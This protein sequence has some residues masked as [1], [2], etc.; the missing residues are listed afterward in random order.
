MTALLLPAAWRWQT[1]SPPWSSESSC[2]R[3]TS[4]CSSRLWP[5]WF[6]GWASPRS[7]RPCSAGK[8]LPKVGAGD[9]RGRPAVGSAAVHLVSSHFKCSFLKSRSTVNLQC[10]VGPRCK[11]KYFSYTCMRAKLLQLCLTLC[12]PMDCSLPGSSV[13]GIFQAQILEQVAIISLSRWSSQPRD[14]TW[15]SCLG[16]QILYGCITWEA[17]IGC[18]KILS[19][20]LWLYVQ[21]VLVGYLFYIQMRWLDSITSSTEMNLSKLQEIVED[22]GAW[23]AAV[24]GVTKS[25]TQLSDWMTTISCIC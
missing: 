3:T 25:W 22:R 16:R 10:C 18:H 12:D 8:G 17:F 19:I 23:C 13:Y 7:S 9:A 6:G 1:A 11:T 21:Q 20:V 4:S 14:R 5:M 15:V 2:R 24:H